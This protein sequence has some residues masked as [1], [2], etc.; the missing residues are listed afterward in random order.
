M[1]SEIV[2][3]D[4]QNPNLDTKMAQIWY[5]EAQISWGL[6]TQIHSRISL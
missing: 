5:L 4:P 1:M 6:T 3:L 2:F